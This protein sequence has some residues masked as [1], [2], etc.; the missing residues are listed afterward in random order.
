MT[1]ASQMGMMSVRGRT[2]GCA[3]E[4]ARVGGNRTKHDL[5]RRGR[6]EPFSLVFVLI[7]RQTLALGDGGRSR[8]AMLTFGCSLGPRLG[9]RRH[10]ESLGRE[11]CGRR[12]QSDGYDRGTGDRGSVG[13]CVLG[14]CRCAAVDGLLRLAK[15]RVDC[16]ANV[17]AT[18]FFALSRDSELSPVTAE[19]TS[20][21]AVT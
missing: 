21:V 16:G 7:A 4:G 3:R 10:L 15:G 8:G 14:H 11:G 2:S 17:S 6:C 13:A 9:G 12:P 5:L 18:P 20:S 19:G 1:E